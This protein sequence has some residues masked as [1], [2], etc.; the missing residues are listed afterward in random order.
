[1]TSRSGAGL[2]LVSDSDSSAGVEIDV[3]TS[4]KAFVQENTPGVYDL[5]DTTAV[6]GQTV[7]SVTP[8]APSYESLL[9][10][11]PTPL[12]KEGEGGVVVKG[13]GNIDLKRIIQLPKPKIED[14]I[15]VDPTIFHV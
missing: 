15:D 4:V 11:P 6:V 8:L 14:I 10:P 9:S 2:D 13:V 7:Q 1:M 5:A 3:Y 12:K